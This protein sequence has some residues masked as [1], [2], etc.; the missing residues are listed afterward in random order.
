MDG[1]HAII[2]LTLASVFLLLF[3]A[4]LWAGLLVWGAGDRQRQFRQA[5]V[6][7]QGEV[8]ERKVRHFRNRPQYYVVYRYTAETPDGRTM[9]V[10]AEENTWVAEYN[11]LVEGTKVF[12]EYVAH[13]PEVSR[14]SPVQKIVPQA[15]S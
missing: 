7:T 2:L 10:N 15:L 5:G 1:S 3:F 8:V 4:L 6:V 14:L 12:V 13:S 9:R 11:R